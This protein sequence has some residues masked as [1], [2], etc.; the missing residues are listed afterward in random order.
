VFFHDESN[1][2]LALSSIV[3]KDLFLRFGVVVTV[4]LKSGD[5][6]FSLDDCLGQDF[7]QPEVDAHFKFD[8][9]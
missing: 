3:E 4:E 5:I 9:K 8:L 2:F 7:V 6:G 1:G